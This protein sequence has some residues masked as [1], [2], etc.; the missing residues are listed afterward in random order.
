MLRAKIRVN[1]PSEAYPAS[2]RVASMMRWVFLGPDPH[3]GRKHITVNGLAVLDKLVAGCAAADFDDVIAVLVDRKPVYI[4]TQQRL[5]DLH[6]A[7]QST[8]ASGALKDGLRDVHFVLSRQAEGLHLLADVT[9][10]DE[11]LVEADEIELRCSARISEFRVQGSEGL[12]AYQ[13]R[14]TAALGEGLFSRAE[15]R[16]AAQASRLAECLSSELRPADVEMVACSPRVVVPGPR[17]VGRF[18]HLS[19]GVR[20]RPRVYRAASK[21][22]RVGAYDDP[23][24]YYYYDPYHDFLS[25]IL[26]GEA[27]ARRW[28]AR[29]VEFVHPDGHTLAIG[30]EALADVTLDVPAEAVRV[31]ANRLVVDSAIPEVGFHPAEA[32]S[33][34]APGWGGGQ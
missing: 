7:L 11:V 33:P 10:N 16:S 1:L 22:D 4:D 32:G 24:V 31:A 28:A 3:A 23:H 8:L 5:D 34:H 18:R 15:E 26:V 27:A 2:G 17:Q 30:G 14:I 9:V 19:F 6:I 12:L 13:Q 21:R 25:W 20:P 29:D